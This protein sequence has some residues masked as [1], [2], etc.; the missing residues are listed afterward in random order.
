[1]EVRKHIEK[2]WLVHIENIRYTNCINSLIFNV[3]NADERVNRYFSIISKLLLITITGVTG[4]F[5][6]SRRKP[7]RRKTVA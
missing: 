2:G 1:M 5:I 4:K 3:Y 7:S 6:K